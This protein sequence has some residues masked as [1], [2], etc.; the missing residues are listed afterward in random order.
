MRSLWRQT[1]WPEHTPRAHHDRRRLY[2]TYGICVCTTAEPRKLTPNYGDRPISS[3]RNQKVLTKSIPVRTMHC[4][5][6]GN[7][8]TG[9]HSGATSLTVPTYGPV[10]RFWT[11]DSTTN[12]ATPIQFL[13][14]NRKIN[15]KE[16]VVK[17]MVPYYTAETLARLI[18]QLEKRQDFSKSGG[19]TIANL[20]MLSKGI[21][22]L[23]QTSTFN[24]DIWY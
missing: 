9:R 10:D 11:G 19:Q 2:G 8:K 18:K 6:W 17:M 21:T 24:E 22:L 12:A 1:S 14:S 23:A 20:V 5:I 4:R 16:N 3:D 15:L 13:Q 7:I